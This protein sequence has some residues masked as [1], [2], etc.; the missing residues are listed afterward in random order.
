MPRRAGPRRLLAR[1]H[2]PAADDDH[3]AA[4]VAWKL[5]RALLFVY[6][7]YLALANAALV[8]RWRV[9]DALS[10]RVAWTLLPGVVHARGVGLRSAPW[11]AELERATARLHVLDLLRGRGAAAT[12]DGELRELSDGGLRFAGEADLTVPVGWRS[13][14][15][16]AT[17]QVSLHVRT[18][19]LHA[20][21]RRVADELRGVVELDPQEATLL[22]RVS[23]ASVWPLDAPV[24]VA[25]ATLLKGAT[26]T[27]RMA[28]PVL[29]A[30]P[31]VVSGEAEIPALQI[32]D[33]R[34]LD[35]ELAGGPGVAS[36]RLW[37]DAGDE[38]FRGAAG[39]T[40]QRAAYTLG[41]A[42]L[43]GDLVA[44]LELEDLDLAAGSARI[45][46]GTIEGTGLT[47]SH[48]GASFGGLQGRLTLDDGALAVGPPWS[49]EGDVVLAWSDVGPIARIFDREGL[50]PG[51]AA[52]VLTGGAF[53]AQA[54]VVRRG[55]SLVLDLARV[56]PWLDARGQLRKGPSGVDGAFLVA[57]GF[58]SAGIRIE[59]GGA[60]VTPLV[61]DR[62]LEQ[63][64]AALDAGALPR[65]AP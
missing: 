20:G 17:A 48:D 28:G 18:G 15:L 25:P 1:A 3:R 46:A 52:G 57:R 32:P 23:R 44:D 55:G 22:V 40:L 33:L 36:V 41:G 59:A 26:I 56:E 2:A 43:Q 63:Q 12:L 11:T 7:A 53:S 8:A 50:V 51:W 61:G 24:E 13:G 39:A 14:R 65:E 54:H 9:P 4:A 10:Y 45:P 6:A 21:A 58:L 62:W 16:M 31:A 60:R 34:W 29:A 35:A 42:V 27:L 38:G 47:L 19:E 64:I 49:F 37:R 30:P 5:V